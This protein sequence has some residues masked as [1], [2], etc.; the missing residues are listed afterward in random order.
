M[1]S[2]TEIRLS[3]DP[4]LGP[5]TWTLVQE[6]VRV[7]KLRMVAPRRCPWLAEDLDLRSAGA[8]W[9]GSQ[10]PEKCF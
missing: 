2:T 4:G 5:L 3:A 7:K 8:L 9:I 6:A 10:A 1:Y